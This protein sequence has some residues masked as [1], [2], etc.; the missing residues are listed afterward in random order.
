MLRLSGP[1]PV[2]LLNGRL[3]KT[4]DEVDGARVLSITRRGVELLRAGERFM[5]SLPTGPVSRTPA[6]PDGHTNRK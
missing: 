3:L 5:V 1:Q 4:G 2:A 6:G